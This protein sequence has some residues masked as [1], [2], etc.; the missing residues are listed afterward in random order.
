MHHVPPLWSARQRLLRY[1]E[2]ET[3]AP[4]TMSAGSALA[5]LED[6]ARAMPADGGDAEPPASVPRP[7]A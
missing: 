5:L 7:M 3:F 6:L 4:R 1:G 2:R